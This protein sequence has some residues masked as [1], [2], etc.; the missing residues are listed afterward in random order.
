MYKARLEC[1][2][3]LIEVVVV[4]DQHD[5]AVENFEAIQQQLQDISNFGHLVVKELPKDFAPI[6]TEWKENKFDKV[7]KVRN[8][9]EKDE[10]EVVLMKVAKLMSYILS[11]TRK[12]T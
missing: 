5:E 4:R 10:G 2:R 1:G 3:L 6:I 7:T 8:Q 11:V 12:Q 9:W